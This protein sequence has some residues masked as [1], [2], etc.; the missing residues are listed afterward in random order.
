MVHE[1]RFINNTAETPQNVSSR[2]SIHANKS[3]NG[4]QYW[5][6]AELMLG[7]HG[8]RK[9]KS[10]TLSITVHCKFCSEEKLLEGSL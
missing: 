9:I 3:E 2:I 5:C 1:E 7:A 8:S 4:V 10:P 6:E